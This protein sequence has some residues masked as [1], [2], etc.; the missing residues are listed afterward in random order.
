MRSRLPHQQ[1]SPESQER[2]TGQLSLRRRKIALVA[3]SHALVRAMYAMLR[4]SQPWGESVT[5]IAALR[6][7]NDEERGT[8]IVKI[9]VG[10][11]G[12]IPANGMALEAAYVNGIDRKTISGADADRHDPLVT[13]NRCLEPPQNRPAS[14]VTEA[15]S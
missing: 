15:S 10:R 1:L 11:Q 9:L 12:R 2:E 13:P 4:N 14:L 8:P 5:P 7:R 6:N 3:T